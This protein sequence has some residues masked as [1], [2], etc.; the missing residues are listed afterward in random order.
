MPPF[1]PNTEAAILARGAGVLGLSTGPVPL[2]INSV[3]RDGRAQCVRCGECVGFACPSDAKN[4]TFNALI[5]RAVASAS[6]DLATNARAVQITADNNG[7]VRGVQFID[8][9]TTQARTIEAR[10]VVV[11]CG[12]IE[13]ARLLLASRSPCHPEGLGNHH[14]Q[15]GRNL[16]GHLYVG[17]FGLFD[18]PVIDMDGP[19]VSIAS[20][21]YNHDL[22]GVIGGGVLANE[23]IKL[24]ILHWYWA[25]PSGMRRWGVE[26]KH[27]MRDSYRRT[28]HLNGPVQ[29]I[30]NPNM[31]VTLDATITD[32]HNV[33]V[34][35]L[36]GRL[37]RESVRAAHALRAKAA[38][39]MH[40]SGARDVW[41]TPISGALT[42]GQHQA[43]TCRMGIDPATSVADAF[44]RVHG[45]ENLWV[46]D[47]SLHVTNGGF[48][49]VLTIYALAFRCA[50]HL[51]A[52]DGG[53]G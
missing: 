19:G 51:A 36:S 10:H 29:E 45:H 33:P 48:N 13:S 21:D 22:D 49:P 40:A 43:G 50:E 1:A 18:E 53:R 47:A 12:A 38:A 41:T 16:Q 20:C 6:C 37:H 26:G 3:P 7:V 52:T 5:P 11:S 42:A 28:S 15:V 34:A 14:D 4:G 25:L 44:G 23:V 27:V 24:P 8:E 2:L 35:R 46:M 9:T 39:W 30:P 17:A 32:R 31:R